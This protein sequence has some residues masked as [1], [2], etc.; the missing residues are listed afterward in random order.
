MQTLLQLS[1]Q[2]DSFL[3]RPQAFIYIYELG[4]GVAV[5]QVVGEVIGV[6]DARQDLFELTSGNLCGQRSPAVTIS[7]EHDE[8][9]SRR[10]SLA[11]LNLLQANLDGL[12]VAACLF[13]HA[14][15]QVN[16]LKAA[17]ML[18]AQLT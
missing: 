3:V 7:Q 17:T 14:P 4:Y 5:R 11:P 8:V 18:R 12:L 10:H 13:A 1:Q 15:A 6:S 2:R 9:W 16:R